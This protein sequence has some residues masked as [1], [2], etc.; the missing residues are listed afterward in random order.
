MGG[1][2]LFMTRI[3]LVYRVQAVI[4]QDGTGGPRQEA[5]ATVY[6]L[7][8]LSLFRGSP[9]IPFDLLALSAGQVAQAQGHIP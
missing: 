8:L 3:F 2:V 5:R 6:G 7:L 4:D 9:H 1:N